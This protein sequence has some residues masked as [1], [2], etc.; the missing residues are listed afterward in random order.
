VLG[1]IWNTA[2]GWR[3]HLLRAGLI[4]ACV[5]TTTA[6]GL[7]WVNRQIDTYPTWA[8]LFGPP[9]VAVGDVRPPAAPSGRGNGG[10]ILTFSVPGPASGMTMPMY[11]YVPSGY[12]T[13]TTTRYPVIEALHGYPGSPLQWQRTLKVV[14]IL[15][16][17]IATARMAPTIVI[18]PYQTPDPLR[19][20]E[21]TNMA[22]GPQTETYL[23]ED[24]PAFVRAHLRVR[25]DRG[26]WGLIGFSAGG[27]CATDLLLRHPTQYAAGASLSGYSSPG[28]PVGNGTEHTT[29]DALWRLSHL[30]IPAVAIYLASAK[31]DT[32]VLRQTEALARVAKS[33][34]SLTTSFINGG[35]HS[36]DTWRAMEAPAFDWLSTWLAGPATSA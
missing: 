29:Y 18:F 9:A 34:I 15:D 11:A 20:T 36:A 24:V 2:R 26:S 33:P 22:N 13:A 31:S 30:P 25:E 4:I 14:Q 12:D 23:T 10:R 6:A 19:D 1:L 3:R 35:G 7:I 32:Q 21:C 27:Y 5:V 17:E 28:V 16:H 8:S